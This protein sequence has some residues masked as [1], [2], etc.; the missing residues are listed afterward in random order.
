MVIDIR[1]F[2]FHPTRLPEFSPF[3]LTVAPQT[4]NLA[5]A[6]SQN[7]TFRGNPFVVAF[8]VQYL[9]KINYTLWAAKDCPQN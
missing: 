2:L 7:E 9:E 3:R 5:L 6:N 8:R 4:D 1:G